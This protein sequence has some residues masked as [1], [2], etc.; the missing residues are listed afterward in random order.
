[1]SAPPELRPGFLAQ[2]TALERSVALCATISTAL[3]TRKVPAANAAIRSL[4]ESAA[5]ANGGAEQ[6]AIRRAVAAYEARLGKIAKLTAQVAR[7]R[8]K[9]VTKLG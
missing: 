7:E 4:F 6:K 1:M 9:L 3:Q 2:R 8:Q 5:A